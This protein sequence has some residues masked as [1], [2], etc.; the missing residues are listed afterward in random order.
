MTNQ[1]FSQ[2]NLPFGDADYNFALTWAGAQEWEEKNGTKHIWHI[3]IY[4]RA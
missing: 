2:I 3:S 1:P 4:D